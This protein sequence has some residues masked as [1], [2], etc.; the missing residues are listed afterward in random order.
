LR[1]RQYQYLP[2]LLTVGQDLRLT[3]AAHPAI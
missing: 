3:A 2:H 1:A